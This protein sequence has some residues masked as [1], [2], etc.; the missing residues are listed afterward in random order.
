MKVLT[1]V[2]HPRVDSL[3]FSVAHKFTQGLIDGGH[4]TEV[5][6]LHRSGFNPVLGEADEPDWSS[7]HKVYSPEVETEMERMKNHDALAYI[8]PVWWYSLPAMLKGYIDRVWNNGFA[9]GSNKLHHKQ[10]LWLGLAADS[11]EGMEKRQYEKMMNQQLN[12]AIAGYCG[13][14]NSRVEILY[15]TLDSNSE[16]QERLLTQAYHL[17]LNYDKARTSPL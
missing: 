9:Y 16:T 14:L 11:K 3:T 10:V 13:I 2:S 4:E 5:L 6:D 8:F 1:V 15:N 17:G 7:D 12:I